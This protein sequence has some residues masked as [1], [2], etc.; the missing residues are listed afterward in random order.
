MPYLAYDEVDFR[1]PVYEEGDVYAR[2]KVHMD[3]M[4]ESVRIVRQCLDRLDEMEGEPWVTDDRKVVLPPRHELHT[5][6]ETLIHHFKLV[7]E[8]YTVPEGEVYT[9][10]ES[11]QG[12]GGLL[13]RL[14][15]RLAAVAR[16][17]PGAE[18]RRPPGDRDGRPGLPRR[19]SR[20]GRRLARSRHGRRRPLMSAPL[21]TRLRKLGAQYPQSTSAVLPALRL[22]QE[23]HGGWLPPE[24][25]RDVA[26]A[27]DL[28][29]A[30]CLSIASF[31]DQFQLEPIGRTHVEVCTNI[32]CALS[33]AQQVVEAFER[34]LGTAAGTT[35]A[36]GRFTLGTVECLGGCGWATVVAIDNRHRLRVTAS[37]VPGDRGRARGGAGRCLSGA[38]SS[39]RER[40]RSPSS[41]SRTTRRPVGS[42]RWRRRVRC[43]LTTSSPSSRDPGS[44]GAAVRGSRPGASGHS[45][46]SPI[47][48]RS[49]TTSS[50]TR[51]SRSPA[52]SRIARS[53]SASRS[54]S[55]RAA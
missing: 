30:Y 39:S 16:P 41:P 17:L 18:L 14:R 26:E 13:P 31:Y 23:E 40:R 48:W 42:R 22:A 50:S 29:P 51:T 33:G 28:T 19:G 36:D 46:P 11:P 10:I 1:V 54:G 35:S 37:D 3:E 27:L 32:S 21:S 20:G 47:S 5:S 24:A 45:S 8:G 43:L 12:R 2:Y 53:C 38:R 15:R 4:R 34:E 7:T 25:L 9:V 49:P 52:R 55:S 44:G 6:M